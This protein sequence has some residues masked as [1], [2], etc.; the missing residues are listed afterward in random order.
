MLGRRSKNKKSINLHPLTND[1]VPAVA[2]EKKRIYEKGGEVRRTTTSMEEKI[3]VRGRVYPCLSTTRSLGDDIGRLVGVIHK[4]DILTYDIIPGSDVFLMM[5]T[6][7]FFTFLEDNDILNVLNFATS[8]TVEESTEIL[9]KK[10]KNCWMQA[11]GNYE[12][13]TLSLCYF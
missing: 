3:F 13:F 10:A 6:D 2:E 9:L 8:S 5:G 4:P 12:D 11:G 7:S 1:H